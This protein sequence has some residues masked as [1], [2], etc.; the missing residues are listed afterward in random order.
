MSLKWSRRSTE[1]PPKRR[2]TLRP[3][4]QKATTSLSKAS[5]VSHVSI[6]LDED[7]LGLSL[8]FSP[9]EPRI[10]FIFVHGLGGGSK[11]TWCKT[12]ATEDFWPQEWLPL[13]EGFAHARIHSFGYDSVWTK[14]VDTRLDI[15]DFGKSLLGEINI[16]PSLMGSDTPIVL[17]GHS[18][19]GIVIKKAYSLARQDKTLSNLAA[20][21]QTICFLATPHR[22][23]DSAQLLHKILQM[24]NSSRAYVTDLR[25]SSRIIQSINDEFR[26]YADELRI[27]SFYETRKLQMGLTSTLIVEK[28]SAT[29]GWPKEEQMPMN[30]DHRSICKFDA[31][32]DQNYVILRNA[33]VSIIQTLTSSYAN[34]PIT[35]ESSET[36]HTDLK[37]LK[38]FL[39]IDELPEDDFLNAED[40]KLPGTCEWIS[41]KD[42]Y[43]NWIDQSY[44]GLRL[45][46]LK[47]KPAS[48][49]SILAGHI[50][51]DL[52]EARSKCS[53]Y[54]FK[55]GDHS[56]TKLGACFRS[57]A[58]QMALRDPRIMSALMQLEADDVKL[59]LENAR[60]VWRK[61]FVN[62]IF[63][64]VIEPQYWVIDALDECINALDC[65]GALLSKLD[66]TI[67]LRILITSRDLGPIEKEFACINVSCIESAL[68]YPD[69]TFADMKS[70]LGAK[71]DFI[72]ARNEQGRAELMQKILGKSRGCFLWTVLV[73]NELSNAHGE[74]EVDRIL[75]EVPR[76]ME[77]LYARSLEMMSRAARSKDIAKAVL[78]WATCTTRP[79][80]TTELDDALRI[81]VGHSFANLA[82]SIETRC[83]QLVNVDRSGR[84]QMVHET[85]RA[86]LLQ[87]DLE[88][89]FAVSRGTAHTRMARTC[90]QYLISDEM[91]PPRSRRK[92]SAT[93]A[94]LKRSPLSVYA[95]DSFSYH[96]ARADVSSNDIL[97]LV[98]N[99]LK[100]NVLSWIE[101]VAQLKNLMALVRA[102]NNLKKYLDRC[103]VARSPLGREMSAIRSWTTDLVRI[104]AKFGNALVTSPSSIYWLL[105]PF[106]PIDT[107]VHGVSNPGRKL[108]VEGV[109]PKYWDDRFSCIEFRDS[110]TTAVASGSDYFAVGLSSGKVVLYSCAT[111]QQYKVLD[112]GEQIRLLL[113]EEGSTLLVSCGNRSIQVWDVACND[114]VPIHQFT[115]PQRILDLTIID[116]SVTVALSSN[117]IAAWNIQNGATEPERPWYDSESN[118]ALRLVPSAVSI[119]AEHQMMA[120]SYRGRPII[121]WDLRED[122]YYGNCGKKPPGGASGP[123]PY[124]ATAL[125]FNPN[126]A[127]DLLAATYQDGDLVLLDP[128]S[129]RIMVRFRADCHTLAASP[130]GRLL[131]SA[132]SL[133]VIQV[134]EFDTLK[135]LYRIQTQACDIRQL[136]FNREGLR[137][138]DVR[139][140]QCNIWEPPILLREHVGNE[141]NS[142]SLSSSTQPALVDISAPKTPPKVTAIVLH[143]TENIAIC[144]NDDRTLTLYQLETGTSIGDLV[145]NR[146]SCAIRTL[147][148]WDVNNLI[149]SADASNL[150]VA[151]RVDLLQSETTAITFEGRLNCGRSIV[152]LCAGKDPTRFIVTTHNSDHLW[153]LSSQE[154]DSRIDA[155]RRTGQWIQHPRSDQ[156][157]LR[158]EATSLCICCWDDWTH[159]IT[160]DLDVAT[161]ALHV[162]SLSP[163]LNGQYIL[164][165]LSEEY[166]AEDTKSLHLLPT[167]ILRTDD[168]SALAPHDHSTNAIPNFAT[169][170]EHIS[171]VLGFSNDSTMIF[172]STNHWVC[173][174]DLEN[175]YTNPSSYSRH[176]FVPYDWFSGV[177]NIVCGVSR[178][179]SLVFARHDAVSCVRGGLDYVEVVEV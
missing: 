106:C 133:G 75:D 138:L 49:K 20:R 162:K 178:D 25:S 27:K 81:D 76:D 30:A 92:G 98:Y 164:I 116:G 123:Y 129:D 150:I 119:S 171:H 179:R 42:Y 94:S 90:L 60:S 152:Q 29:L 118:T 112:H 165:E 72:L 130:N 173:S 83:G 4:P 101:V 3:K 31:P 37:A 57:I 36:H 175:L 62:T 102:A 154:I 104:A 107:A 38:A 9:A 145:H 32:S 163:C 155:S 26:Q 46:W 115:T 16:S 97:A 113:F 121:L 44:K 50:I 169:L 99:F 105:P 96:L 135:V 131:V 48:G 126:Q 140:T 11:K 160:V 95:C 136:A 111:C 69:D 63:P 43:T 172:L 100:L 39:D 108:S 125:V 41:T 53:Y 142:D 64:L 86:Y 159:T 17:V 77:S 24:A 22:G 122:T 35:Q 78:R 124:W 85:A 141:T 151:W 55:Y 52:N 158:V 137:F 70:L 128:F 14:R 28:N 132:N 65:L 82:D 56:K 174:I 148:L 166:G 74:D 157:V 80:T 51:S 167:S 143:P 21:I 2:L 18:M 66:A 34:E 103:S 5:T 146:A 15:D 23:S 120:I 144:G 6:G 84:V 170:C 8:L 71:A 110:R 156:H 153:S 68:I 147:I 59:D 117:R 134:Y 1:P 109:S 93:P 58:F 127:I 176:F 161:S 73:V 149:L 87:E 7:H 13:E 12:G 139:G 88:S 40:A 114:P 91:R 168:A 177:R 54:F 89:E 19:G 45:L 47:A 61:L 33:F 79:L 67:S 10:D